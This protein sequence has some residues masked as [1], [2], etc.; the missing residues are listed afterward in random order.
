MTPTHSLQ[1]AK[2]GGVTSSSVN[3]NQASHSQPTSYDRMRWQVSQIQ[4][5]PTHEPRL[6][7]SQ[8]YMT[9]E[10]L[11]AAAKAERI[12]GKGNQ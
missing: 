12:A 10:V 8:T 1:E 3:R 5:A 7:P 4:I 2:S 6:D 11:E 9:L